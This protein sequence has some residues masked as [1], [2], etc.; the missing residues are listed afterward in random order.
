MYVVFGDNEPFWLLGGENQPASVVG[1]HS[2]S[3]DGWGAGRVGPVFPNL[4]TAFLT[5]LLVF[6]P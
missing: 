6:A 4:Q 1:A 2:V 3:A 5:S